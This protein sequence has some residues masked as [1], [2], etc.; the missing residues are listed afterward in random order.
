MLHN[1]GSCVVGRQPARQR[2]RHD[3]EPHDRG[4]RDRRAE[5]R[6]SQRTSGHHPHLQRAG[7]PAADRR[8]VCSTRPACTSWSSTTAAPTAPASSPTS[9]PRPTRVRVHVMHRAAKAGLGAAYLA[10]FGW[11]LDRGLLG[12][13]RDGRRRLAR[14]GGAAPLLDAR[15]RGRR[16]RPRLPLRPRR[17][18]WAT[19]RGAGVLSRAGNVYSRLALGVVC[20]T[21]PAATGPTG[22]GAARSGLARSPRRATASRSTWRGASAP[23]SGREVPITFTERDTASRR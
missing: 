8:T 21:S 13:R 12:A 2:P 23:G 10:G 20:T 5:H 17:R 6:P 15:R 4:S 9:W 11:G 7:E 3:E 19:G 1:G 14:P 22:G 16:P 18:R